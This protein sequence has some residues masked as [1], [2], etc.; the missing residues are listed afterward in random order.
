MYLCDVGCAY[1]LGT[2]AEAKA[3]ARAMD[4]FA[5]AKTKQIAQAK[6]ELASVEAKTK[7]I[8]QAEAQAYAEAKARTRAMTAIAQAKSK[9][10]AQAKAELASVEAARKEQE[11]RVALEMVDGWRTTFQ[12]KDGAPPFNRVEVPSPQP[13]IILILI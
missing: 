4:A 2:V 11:Q 13:N 10:V 9:Q 6:A 1:L 5:Q 7:Q 8:A 12:L 3:R